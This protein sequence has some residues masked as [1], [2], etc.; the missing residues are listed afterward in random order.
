[1]TSDLELQQR[2]SVMVRSMSKDIRDSA[3]STFDNLYI[4]HNENEIS[5][6]GQV[7]ANWHWD[8]LVYSQ[9]PELM[10][11]HEMM[12]QY[13]FKHNIN[14]DKDPLWAP[15]WKQL[16]RIV[17]PKSFI[18]K[19]ES[20]PMVPRLAVMDKSTPFRKEEGSKRSMFSDINM[21]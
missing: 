13:A 7:C 11:D 10:S 14:L 8:I 17:M 15:L 16:M 6:I 20:F 12:I 2:A 19:I 18:K 9:K 3:K 21:G 4:R 5:E 1:L